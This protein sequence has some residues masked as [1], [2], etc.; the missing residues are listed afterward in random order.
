M[1]SQPGTSSGSLP[2]DGSSTATGEPTAKMGRVPDHP[3]VFYS[4][5][6]VPNT[7]GVQY[8]LGKTAAPTRGKGPS[9][10]SCPLEP[11]MGLGR[12]LP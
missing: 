4:E 10:G 7:S 11:S 2:K 6:T 9:R 3:V 12:L 1:S 8:R 5:G